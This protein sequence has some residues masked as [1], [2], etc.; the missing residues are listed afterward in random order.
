MLGSHSCVQSRSL[1]AGMGLPLL[2]HW[3]VLP[4]SQTRRRLAHCTRTLVCPCCRVL[5][6]DALHNNTGEAVAMEEDDSPHQ[7]TKASRAFT[8]SAG[9]CACHTALTLCV[10]VGG[11]GGVAALGTPQRF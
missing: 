6:L 1:C 2:A 3:C 9:T 8:V 10:C 4:L 5:Q 7:H 11:G